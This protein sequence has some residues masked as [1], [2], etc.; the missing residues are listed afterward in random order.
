MNRWPLVVLLICDT[1][2]L[3]YVLL[4]MALVCYLV[5]PHLRD[6]E[7]RCQPVINSCETEAEP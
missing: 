7:C 4:L 6:G 2:E 5:R 1:L 3:L